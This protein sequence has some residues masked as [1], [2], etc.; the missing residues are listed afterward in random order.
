MHGRP[1]RL[2]DVELAVHC[3]LLLHNKPAWRKPLRLLL[4]RW[5]HDAALVEVRVGDAR[6]VQEMN[7]RV[8]RAQLAQ[9]GVEIL[10]QAVDGVRQVP[11]R[12]PQEHGD[13]QRVLGLD[14]A[15]GDWLRRQRVHRAPGEGQYR[16][17]H[18]AH[19]RSLST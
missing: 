12:S 9:R 7:K 11:H 15:R 16:Q 4:S 19:A 8:D 1:R 18:R 6:N 2:L 3:L 10:V 17:G 14:V 5:Q 13:A